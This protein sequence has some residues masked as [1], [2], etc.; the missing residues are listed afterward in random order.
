ATTTPPI[1]ETAP[2]LPGRIRRLPD[3]RGCVYVPAPAR[4]RKWRRRSTPPASCVR[5]CTSWELLTRGTFPR[6]TAPRRNSFRCQPWK[7]RKNRKAFARLSRVTRFVRLPPAEQRLQQILQRATAAQNARL[8]CPHAALQNLGD[9]LVAQSFQVPQNYRGAKYR[10][11]LLQRVL[12]RVLNL[13][14]RQL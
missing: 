9:L 7:W 14:R 2:I 8:H 1:S 4:S 10:G 5:C 6:E 12:H 13:V 11:D 3:A